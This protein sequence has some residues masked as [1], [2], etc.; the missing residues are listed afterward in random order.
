MKV[1][2]IRF[3]NESDFVEVLFLESARIYR[4]L[5]TNMKYHSVL[6]EL[7]H[8]SSEGRP[9]KVCFESID[10]DIIEEVKPI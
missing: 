7:E 4:L 10:S 3:K 2:K 6:K 5:R 8:S 9:V 1:A